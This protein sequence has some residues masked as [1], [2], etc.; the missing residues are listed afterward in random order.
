[1]RQER[2]RRLQHVAQKEAKSP[3]HGEDN[4]GALQGHPPVATSAPSHSPSEPTRASRSASA[5]RHSP[6]NL[7]EYR[8]ELDSANGNREV[9]RLHYYTSGHINPA[10]VH[11]Y[12]AK[13]RVKEYQRHAPS[14]PRQHSTPPRRQPHGDDDST[15]V[16]AIMPPPVDSSAEQWTKS[17]LLRMQANQRTLRRIREKEKREAAFAV[18]QS[19]ARTASAKR[20]PPLES[21]VVSRAVAPPHQ[22]T[23][24]EEPPVPLVAAPAP[25]SL[26]PHAPRDYLWRS[27]RLGDATVRAPTVTLRTS[28]PRQQSPLRTYF[29][30]SPLRRFSGGASQSAHA[31]QHSPFKPSLT[32]SSSS[33][34][35]SRAENAI[36]IASSLERRATST[37]MPLSDSWAAPLR[38]GAAAASGYQPIAP[39]LPT[40]SSS[41]PWENRR[42]WEGLSKRTSPSR[43]HG[44]LTSFTFSSTRAPAAAA[45]TRDKAEVEVSPLTPSSAIRTAPRGAGK[46]AGEAA[47]QS[48]VPSAA[49]GKPSLLAG[50]RMPD[51]ILKRD[52]L[53]Q[54]S[55]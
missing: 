48:T 18:A 28:P 27:D 47:A 50:F 22:A 20:K 40:G 37:Q 26:A 13:G 12:K 49:Q 6:H 43:T 55:S 21:T 4:G 17:A 54:G 35:T 15:H 1:M 53:F 30:N 2:S 25:I 24:I 31:S 39:Q 32:Y 45:A 41:A 42:A 34:H 5:S 51:T 44:E 11:F 33:L 8:R 10:D 3:T 29:T 9:F 46:A 52:D 38:N 7:E 19:G 23:P 16:L 36:P 14:P